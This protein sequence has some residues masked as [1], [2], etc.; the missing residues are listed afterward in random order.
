MRYNK[1]IA[2]IGVLCFGLRALCQ[3]NSVTGAPDYVLYDFF[4]TRVMWLQDQASKAQ[5]Q[6]KD[7][8]QFSTMIQQ[9]AG[10][11]T[12]QASTLVAIASDWRT[13]N[14]AILG[15]IQSL[16]ATGARGATSPQ[17]QALHAQRQQ[18]VLGHL[19]Q[20]QTALGPGPF[21]LLDLFVRRTTIMSGPGVT[22]AGK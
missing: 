18:L 1:S 11:T 15:Q 6:G 8:S 13:N 21:Y 10:L 2:L 14:A 20:L 17:L 7:G 3:V 16:A 12:Q 5:S 9:Q 19:S 22:P 4:F